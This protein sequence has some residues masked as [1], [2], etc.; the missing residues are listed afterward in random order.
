MQRIILYLIL[1]VGA[2]SAKAQVHGQVIKVMTYN[3]H[4]GE[5]MNGKLDIQGIATVI[6]AT[7]PDLVALQE[8]DSATLRIGKA[9]ILQ[10]L[11]DATGMYIYFAK[12]MDFDGGGYGNGVLSRYPIQQAQT[13]ALP[14]KGKD[15]EPRSAAIVTVQLP[16]DSLLRFAS[17]HLDHLEDPTDRLAQIQLIL[18]Q[19]QRSPVPMILAGDL[20][21]LPPSKEIIL[22]KGHFTD[23]TEKL[24]PTWPSDKPTQKLDYI[25]LSGKNRWHV[26]EAHVVEETIASDHRPVIAELLLK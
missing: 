24:G 2:L 8:V 26:S 19:Q 17:A 25:L 11:A 18:Q 10:E 21:A 14:A 13:L 3:I 15:G 12:A 6:L 22:L 9:D 4:H 7:N 23:A 5:N 16:G 1:S 20:N